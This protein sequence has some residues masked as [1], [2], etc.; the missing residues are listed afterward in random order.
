VFKV[1]V[2][3]RNKRIIDGF[4]ALAVSTPSFFK[5]STSEETEIARAIKSPLKA[6]PI[7]GNMRVFMN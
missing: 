6:K 7:K 3:L 1:P 4:A 2:F 5:G